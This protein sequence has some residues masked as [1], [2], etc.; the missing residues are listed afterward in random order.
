MKVTQILRIVS[1]RR[2]AAATDRERAGRW[3]AALEE[4]AAQRGLPA[5][6]TR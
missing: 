1:R 5:G 2:A 4:E 3:L 6:D